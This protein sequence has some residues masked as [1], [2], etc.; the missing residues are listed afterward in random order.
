MDDA[1]AGKAVLFQQMLH[2]LVVGVGVGTQALAVLHAPVQHCRCHALVLSGRCQTVHRAIG[3]GIVQPLAVLNGGVGGVCP[4]NKCKYGLD[5]AVDHIEE[6]PVRVDILLQQFLRREII[7][8]LGRVAR[9]LHD[10]T[11]MGIDLQDLGQIP[12]HCSTKHSF[13][14][15]FSALRSVRHSTLRIVLIVL[16]ITIK[17][18]FPHQST[19]KCSKTAKSRGCCTFG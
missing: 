3:Q 11:C 18:Q 19:L 17:I 16:Q 5:L 1:A 7:P 2:D 15:V 14:L 6:Q 9:C 10:C 4:Q 13:H 12:S 8:P